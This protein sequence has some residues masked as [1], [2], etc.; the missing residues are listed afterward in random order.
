MVILKKLVYQSRH[1]GTRENDLL[2]GSFAEAVLPNLS[3]KELVAYEALLNESDSTV[4]D[5]ITGRQP[6]PDTSLPAACGII[7]LIQDFHKCR[8]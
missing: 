7:R 6:I 5:W 8:M 1:R 4:F 2:L 3:P